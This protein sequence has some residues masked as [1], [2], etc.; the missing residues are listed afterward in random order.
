MAVG[1][2]SGEL[3]LIYDSGLF[4]SVLQVDDK[5]KSEPTILDNGEFL[6]I[7]IG[8]DNGIMYRVVPG[9][10]GYDELVTADSKIKSSVSVGVIENSSVLLFGANDKFLYAVDGEGN[11]LDN[12]P[13]SLESPAQS[14]SSVFSDLD[15]DGVNEI[16]AGSSSEE[17]YVFHAD[18]TP[19]THFPMKVGN[20][21]TSTPLVLDG[22][23]DGDL[24]IVFGTNSGIAVIDIKDK[25]GI[26]SD[27]WSMFRGN[28]ERDGCRFFASVSQ[29]GDLN[30]DSIVN[31][32]D[33]VILVDMVINNQS[34]IIAD[35][36]SD[37]SV[38]VLDVVILV[39][40]IING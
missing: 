3:F 15:G 37:G 23:M 36:N 40:A 8:N 5:F 9:V 30:D 26:D 16:I 19:Y 35:L 39:S 31:I 10:E 14:I 6:S 18:G 28:V 38:D 13:V 12:W 25:D 29:S 17:I 4:Q 27:S 21:I 34:G 2:E 11:S 20:G 1:T 7:Y 22:D 24:D 32:L 33:V